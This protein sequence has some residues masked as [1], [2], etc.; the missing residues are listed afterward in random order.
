MTPAAPHHSTRHSPAAATAASTP[1]RILGVVEILALAG[2]LSVFGFAFNLIGLL[3]LIAAGVTDPQPWTVADSG[4]RLVGYLVGVGATVGIIA[5]YL[6]FRLG[7]DLTSLGLIRPPRWLSL[8]VGLVAGAAISAAGIGLAWSTGRVA[9]MEPAVL[10]GVGLLLLIGLLYLLTYL[11]Q[12]AGEEIVARG[13]LLRGLS[14]WIG[15]PVAVAVQALFFVAIHLGNPNLTPTYAVFVLAFAVFAALLVL[16]QG[17]LWGVIG[18]HGGYNAMF[19]AGAQRGLGLRDVGDVANLNGP[20]IATI[21]LF[22]VGIIVLAVL[23][24][25]RRTT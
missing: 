11:M 9:P 10:P 4:A 21:P 18:L 5:L 17:H 3:P 14:W 25:R 13:L 23:L 6:K 24:W 19:F 12:G 7:V 8:V 1:R 2:V 16:V 15:L 22:L 20:D